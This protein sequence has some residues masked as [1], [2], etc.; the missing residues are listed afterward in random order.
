MNLNDMVSLIQTR[1]GFRT[2]LDAEI[3]RE[4]QL[5]Q[6]ELE[7][8][9]TFNPH[10]LWRAKDICICPECLDYVLPAGFIRL[11]EMN[12]PLYQDNGSYVAFELDKGIAVNTFEPNKVSGCPQYFSIYSNNLRLDK[13]ACGILRLFYITATTQLTDVIVEN[14][15]TEHAFHLLMNKAGI[16]MA[17][18]IQES[19]AVDR[20]TTDYLVAYSAFKKACVA[21]EDQGM[22][23]SR[24]GTLYSSPVKQIGGWY[25]AGS[26]PCEECA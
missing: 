9:P 15:W 17:T 6:Y 13:R 1:L 3:I 8:D 23:I 4:I 20:F 18:N 24:A 2:D 19:M 7:R 16:A 14:L 22:N 5:A 12:N 21:Y 25:E 11:D 26:I 10:F